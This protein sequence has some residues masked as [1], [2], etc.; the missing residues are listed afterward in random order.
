M[1]SVIPKIAIVVVFGCRHKTEF[2]ERVR[3]AVRFVLS[4]SIDPIFIFTGLDAEP[5]LS[6]TRMF[7]KYKIIFENESFDT[8]SNVRNTMEL[9]RKIQI[10]HHNIFI[11]SSWYHIPKIKLLLKGEGMQLQKQNFI[12]SYKDVKP[13]NVIIEPFALLATYFRFNRIPLITALKRKLGYVV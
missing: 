11:V 6:V 1:N 9:I 12:R 5:P 2:L 7:G 13:I 4:Q 8:M 3:K 10:G